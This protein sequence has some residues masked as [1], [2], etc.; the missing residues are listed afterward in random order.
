MEQIKV[1]H[2]ISISVLFSIGN[3]II[4]LGNDN[5]HL[6]QTLIISYCLSVLILILY[7]KLLVKYPNMNLFE[8]IEYKYNNIFGKIIIMLYLIMLFYNSICIVFGFIDF[9][10]T[11][12]Q[13]DFLSK[14]LIM[15]INFVLIGYVLK[16]GLSVICRFAQTTFVIVLVLLSILF[17]VGIKDIDASNLLPLLPLNK[18]NTMFQSYNLLINPFLE[19]TI[20][21]NVFCKLKN[22]KLKNKLYYISSSVSLLVLFIISIQIQ[23][24]LGS[25]YS[26]YLNYPYY[27]AISCINMSKIVIKIESLSL[28]VV[29]LCAFTKFIFIVYTL[30]LGFNSLNHTK[31]RYYYPILLLIHILS[32]VVFDNISELNTLKLYYN[33]L[34]FIIVLLIPILINSKK[35]INHYT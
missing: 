35:I 8:I 9:I 18:N 7:Q 25:E 12:N 24:I 28:L 6:W 20:L 11:I 22:N 17:I 1:R 29:Y 2:I 34:F 31:K 5:K 16:S 19:L 23:G 4:S 10:S 32:L 21:F 30:I 15:L 3:L 27:T 26:A 14:E 33:L 13:Y